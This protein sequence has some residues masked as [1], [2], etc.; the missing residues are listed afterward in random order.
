MKKSLKELKEIYL[1]NNPNRDEADLLREVVNWMN[2]RDEHKNSGKTTNE[3]I[4]TYLS[5]KN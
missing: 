5:I 2:R 1:K 3:L 4:K